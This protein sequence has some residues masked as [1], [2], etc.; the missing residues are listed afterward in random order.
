MWQCHHWPRGEAQQGE[1][2]INH[3][4]DSNLSGDHALA[5]GRIGTMITQK[6]DD[7]VIK[8]IIG[9]TII[10]PVTTELPTKLYVTAVF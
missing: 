1:A 7:S 9:V 5:D 3:Q 8:M 10:M 4:G 2:A 6:L